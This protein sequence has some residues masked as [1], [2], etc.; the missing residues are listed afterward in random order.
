MHMRVIAIEDNR[1]F[2]ELMRSHLVK[3]GFTVDAAETLDTG[4]TLNDHSVALRQRE[5]ALLEALR[6][7]AG[8]PVHR[9]MLL[10]SRYSLD[11][12]IG[13]NTRDVYVHHLRRRL[14]E[15]GAGVGI[16]TMRDHGYA[17]RAR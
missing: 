10:S 1:Q 11:E 16:A 8:E 4:L 15:A 14:A 13:S 3:H 2:L 6:R 5:A 7:R 12:E 17:V 9:E